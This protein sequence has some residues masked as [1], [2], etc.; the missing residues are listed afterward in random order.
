MRWVFMTN[1][2]RPAARPELLGKNEH[3]VRGRAGSAA[4]VA[5]AVGRASRLGGCSRVLGRDGGDPSG[6][7]RVPVRRVDPV[8]PPLGRADIAYAQRCGIHIGAAGVGLAGGRQVAA[9]DRPRRVALD[10][11]GGG[12]LQA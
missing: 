12:L 7:G 4:R 10:P 1:P 6:L 9:N 2:G 11:A 3:S 8:A 5:R